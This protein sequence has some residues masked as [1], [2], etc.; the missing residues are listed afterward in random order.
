MIKN[1]LCSKWMNTHTSGLN[2]TVLTITIIKMTMVKIR[3]ISDTC[4]GKNM[5]SV[6]KLLKG[7][8]LI[9]QHN[10]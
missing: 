6:S 3:E 9:K 1:S 5:T 10:V 8:P 7:C 2:V 4:K